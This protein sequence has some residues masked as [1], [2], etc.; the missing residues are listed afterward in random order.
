MGGVFNVVNLHT[1]HYAGNNPGLDDYGPCYMRVLIGIAETFIG[2]NLKPEELSQLVNELITGQDPAVDNVSTFE[3]KGKTYKSYYVNRAGEVVTEAL[4][5][6]DPKNKYVVSV[7]KQ[8]NANFEEVKSKAVGTVIS[9]PG[10][11]QE[12]D[13]NR[14]FRWDPFHRLDNSKYSGRANEADTRYVSIEKMPN[15]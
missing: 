6:L 14:R 4:K 1:Y 5:I 2:R 11:Y 9:V 7:A 13:R 10:H 12:G 3:V 8:G 15:N